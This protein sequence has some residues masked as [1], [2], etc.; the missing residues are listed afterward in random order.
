M[1]KKKL[2]LISNP[3]VSSIPIVECG[4]PYIN[5]KKQ[6]VL[7]YG[8][9]PIHSCGDEYGYLRTTVYEKLINAQKYLPKGFSFLV[10]EGYRSMSVQHTLFENHLKALQT[11]YPRWGRKKIFHEALRAVSPT[12]EWD[13][14]PNVPPHSTGGAI[15]IILVDKDRK[16]LPM[17]ICPWETAQDMQGVLCAT[18]S[19]E[20]SPEA[21][22]HRDVMSNVLRKVGFINYPTEYWHW[23]YGDRYHAY[24]AGLSYAIYGAMDPHLK[25]F[26]SS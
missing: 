2:I 1:K 17:G 25:S 20:I 5:L 23:S 6:N 9:K 10:L 7:F 24:H 16:S 4:E 15:D 14:Q 18:A 19:R 8:P 12:T 13:G 22:Y 11:N 3:D 21:R 26:E